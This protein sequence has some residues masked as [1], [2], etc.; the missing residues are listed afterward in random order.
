MNVDIDKLNEMLRIEIPK[1]YIDFIESKEKELQRGF[2][3]KTLLVL[4][5][6]LR[7]ADL[8]YYGF[9]RFYL[10]GDGC[11]NYYFC[12][13]NLESKKVFLL[14]HDPEGIEQVNVDLTTFLHS[15]TQ[16]NPI[17]NLLSESEIV[18]AK[19]EM[20]G[21]SILS[22]IHMREWLDVLENTK[23]IEH[24]GYREMINPFTGEAT[25]LDKP[26]LA[27]FNEGDQKVYAV[28]H[29]G[30]ISINSSEQHYQAIATKLANELSCNVFVTGS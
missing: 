1:D 27:Q 19:S 4:N 18:I 26:G 3:P 7:E 14:A 11:G 12:D 30:R 5:L 25:H 20:P 28:L 9:D 16:E 29:N 17:Y 13:G 24:K 23:G 8:E 6:E 10:S 21:E 2:D 15:A 22:P